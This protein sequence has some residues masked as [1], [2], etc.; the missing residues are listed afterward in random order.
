MASSALSASRYTMQDRLRRKSPKRPN[1]RKR[2]KVAY[3]RFWSDCGALGVCTQN[4]GPFN[5]YSKRP[6][7]RVTDAAH[8]LGS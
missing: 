2:S 5:Q 6:G 1:I 4:L 8:P 7:T 3:K